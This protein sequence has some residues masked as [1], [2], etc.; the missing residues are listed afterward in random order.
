[1]PTTYGLFSGGEPVGSGDGGIGTPGAPRSYNSLSNWLPVTEPPPADD[2]EAAAAGA[3]SGAA[4][5]RPAVNFPTDIPS[6]NTG[7]VRRSSSTMIRRRSQRY[8]PPKR[9]EIGQRGSMY[10]GMRPG[11]SVTSVAVRGARASLQGGQPL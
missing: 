4:A 1:M 9:A 3:S 5:V 7:S 2:P 10:L 11:L 8:V 6:E